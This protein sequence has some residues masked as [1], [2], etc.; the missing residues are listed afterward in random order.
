MKRV[1]SFFLPS[2]LPTFFFT[3]SLPDSFLGATGACVLLAAGGA[4]HPGGM[5][6]EEEEGGAALEWRGG[7]ILLQDVE[8]RE[9]SKEVGEGGASP[10]VAR[11]REAIWREERREEESHLT[12]QDAMWKGR[13]GS[14]LRRRALFSFLGLRPGC[15]RHRL[16]CMSTRQ[17]LFY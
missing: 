1:L 13:R 16:A 17:Q 14:F 7:G 10:F 3:R 6:E 4:S 12:L 8:E 11:E 5:A 15:C 2:P 9:G